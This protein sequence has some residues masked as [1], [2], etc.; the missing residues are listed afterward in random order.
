MAKM[1]AACKTKELHTAVGDVVLFTQHMHHSGQRN[2]RAANMERVIH[3][4]YQNHRIVVSV[5]F[6]RDNEFSELWDR[7]FKMRSAIFNDVE[8]CGG[9][10]L[11]MDRQIRPEEPCAVHAA[12]RDIESNPLPI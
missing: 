8:V 4:G 2:R 11:G 1:V 7:Y 3:P 9:Q 5:T 6:G 10:L 12:V